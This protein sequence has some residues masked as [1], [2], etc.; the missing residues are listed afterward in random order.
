MCAY[1]KRHYMAERNHV[2]KAITK[3]QEE[4]NA[5]QWL[6]KEKVVVEFKQKN[7]KMAYVSMKN[8]MKGVVLQ[9]SYTER[10]L[11]MIL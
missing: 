10:Q 9:L 2:R 4:Q 11:Q 6:R 3:Y 8:N 1:S 7:F 5:L